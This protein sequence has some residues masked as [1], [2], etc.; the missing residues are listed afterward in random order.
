MLLIGLLMVI[1]PLFVVAQSLPDHTQ[2]HSMEQRMVTMACCSGH[3]LS[4]PS[5]QLSSN[6]AG[7]TCGDIPLQ[8]CSLAANQGSCTPPLAALIPGGVTPDTR[9]TAGQRFSNRDNG[10]RSVVLD[11]LTPPPNSSSV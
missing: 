2:N 3:E 6:Q 1:Q 4:M 10:Y 7:M 9:L 11:T 5:D 8:D